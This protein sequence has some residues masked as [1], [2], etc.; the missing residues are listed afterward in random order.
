MH[1]SFV[2]LLINC[3]VSFP[4][5]ESKCISRVRKFSVNQNLQNCRYLTNLKNAQINSFRLDLTSLSNCTYSVENQ[6]RYSQK[7]DVEVSC[8]SSS[9][10]GDTGEQSNEVSDRSRPR[11]LDN[12]GED[13]DL[14]NSINYEEITGGDSDTLNQLKLIMLEVD[15]LRQDGFRVPKK[16]TTESWKELLTLKS[17]NQKRKFLEFL[18]VIEIRKLN[19]KIKKEIKKKEIG[20]KLDELAKERENNDHIVYGFQGNTIF[21][22]VYDTTI[23][24]F[25]NTRL[26]QAMLH[27]I[28]IVIDCGYDANM[29]NLENKLCA[30][31]LCFLFAENRLDR[32]PFNIHFCNVNRDGVCYK[33]LKKFIPTLDDPGF[34]MNIS[35]K[36][37]TTLFPKEKLVYLTP[38]CRTELQVFNPDDVYIVGKYT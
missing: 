14:F 9:K 27:G 18:W 10:H 35:E 6:R 24:H 29:T 5:F 8:D 20:E 12:E 15:V 23:N 19:E 28:D 22:R 16:L 36:H 37:Y 32:D 13:T 2:K 26:I 4:A 7:V 38:H 3:D 25:D 33:H 31:Q 1:R 34:P 11:D 30:K 21:M 17:R